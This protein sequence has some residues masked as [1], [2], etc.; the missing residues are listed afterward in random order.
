MA[1]KI[2]RGKRSDMGKQPSSARKKPSYWERAAIDQDQQ[3]AEVQRSKISDM[4]PGVRISSGSDR[5]SRGKGGR[6]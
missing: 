6:R 2:T 5:N 1:A 3:G 4:E